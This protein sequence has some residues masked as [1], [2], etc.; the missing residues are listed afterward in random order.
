MRPLPWLANRG[1]P[2][3][4]PYMGGRKTGTHHTD[5]TVEREGGPGEGKQP[6]RRVHILETL[7][8]MENTDSMQNYTATPCGPRTCGILALAQIH[9]LTPLTTQARIAHI[10]ANQ[11]NGIKL[12]YNIWFAINFCFF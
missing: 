8:V 10:V 9:A 2:A 6:L 4:S 5:E 1:N 7:T 3:I 11:L 12:H